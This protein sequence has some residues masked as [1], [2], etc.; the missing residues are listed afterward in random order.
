MDCIKKKHMRNFLN[1]RIHDRNWN[2]TKLIQPL[3][4]G[5]KNGISE[6]EDIATNKSQTL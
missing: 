4:E 1:C 3:S 5:N 2:L 6:L